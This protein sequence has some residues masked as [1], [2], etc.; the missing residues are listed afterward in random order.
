MTHK[1][2]VLRI[3]DLDICLPKGADRPLAVENI[4][5]EVFP[6][7]ILCI[8]G[9][10][11]SGKSMSSNAIMGLLPPPHVKVVRGS[12][13]LEGQNLL[14]LNESQ[15]QKIRGSRVGMIF[16]E[17]MTALNPV[18]KV[19]DQLEEVLLAHRHYSQAERKARIIEML[20]DVGLPDPEIIGDS[21]PFALSGGQRQRV[22]ISMA[23]ALEPAVLIADEPTTALDVTTQAQILK[24]IKDLQHSHAMG[25]IFITHDFGVVAEIA[26]RVIVMQE[27]RIVEQGSAQQ[28][29]ND[30]QHPY[31]Q[32]LIAAIPTLQT[33]DV[34]QSEPETVVSVRNLCK[35]YTSK[36]GFWGKPG[37]TVYASKNI[38][39][40][41]R[42]GETLGLVGESG[43]GKS[44]VGRSI[45]RLHS[46]DSGEVIFNGQNILSLND[47]QI[48]PVRRRIQM[49]F[50]DPY[51]SLNPR[52]KVGDI[53]AEGPVI[54]G[55][56]K[57]QAYAQAGKLLQL[58]G[59]DKS[60]LKRYPHEFSGGQRQR[61][62]IARALAMEP[63][64][65]I[66]DEAVSALDVSVQAQVLEL[67][68]EIKD[69]MQLAM[70]FV[71]HDLRVAAKICDR[72]AVMKQGEIVE[73]G[74]TE[75]VFGAPKHDYT[76]LLLEAIPGKSWDK[77]EAAPA[78]NERLATAL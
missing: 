3:K 63:Q 65:L 32:K 75:E 9:E 30:P 64:L 66:A 20:K 8:V 28:V 42:K 24:L 57:Q 59:L 29:L 56:S 41:I 35:T 22:M 6:G 33:R 26:D 38:S 43:S 76:K 62:G 15:M 78:N 11:G 16:Q 7:E 69:K 58:V 68:D 39:F 40:D 73:Y 36:A 34:S 72:I 55:E 54:H 25:V 2:A 23:L 77:Q 46:S 61:I 14:S 74:T 67:L 12:I 1:Q 48:M 44:T 50:Q 31:T 4:N 51:A 52:R 18:M 10:S 45:I 53:I 13:E 71:T 21:Y 60:V 5:F 19:G 37:R 70:L 17:P 27:G 49:I 47:K